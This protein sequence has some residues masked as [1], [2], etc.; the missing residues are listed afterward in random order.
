MGDLPSGE[1]TVTYAPIKRAIHEFYRKG[2]LADVDRHLAGRAHEQLLVLYEQDHLDGVAE[3]TI[4]ADHHDLP[5]YV[6]FELNAEERRQYGEEGIAKMVSASSSRVFGDRLSR[7][8][9]PLDFLNQGFGQL[10]QAT[11][12]GNHSAQDLVVERL[13]GD[14]YRLSM[15]ISF[16]L[17]PAQ[18]PEEQMG[19]IVFFEKNRSLLLPALAQITGRPYLAALQLDHVSRGRLTFYPSRL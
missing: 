7:Y 3:S 14:Q 10:V 11:F 19:H 18:T 6:Y 16:L 5:A 13:A 12:P 17:S 8:A 2:M 1:R 9:N 4:V 15:D